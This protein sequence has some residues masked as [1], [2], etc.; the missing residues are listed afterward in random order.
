MDS[1]KNCPACGSS[2]VDSYLPGER[3]N[4]PNARFYSR[5]IGIELNR[6]RIEYWR[7]PD[8]ETTWDR[9]TGNVVDKNLGFYNEK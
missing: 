3:F 5:L 4:D 1:L 7:C 2:W 9:F 6:D 8:C